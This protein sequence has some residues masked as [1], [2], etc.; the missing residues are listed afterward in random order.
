MCWC[1]F[2]SK[3][4]GTGLQ[5]T[6]S[7]QY[8]WFSELKQQPSSVMHKMSLNKTHNCFQ[9]SYLN[10]ASYLIRDQLH[11]ASHIFLCCSPGKKPEYWGKLC[12][13]KDSSW[14]WDEEW[15]ISYRVKSLGSA[16]WNHHLFSTNWIFS[17]F[18]FLYRRGCVKFPL[19]DRTWFI[20]LSL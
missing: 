5:M 8:H 6:I 14:Q 2:L 11:H 12:A 4:P 16:M 10:V 19:T 17:V 7:L 20:V 9:V 18:I 3:S 15:E 1:E 13:L